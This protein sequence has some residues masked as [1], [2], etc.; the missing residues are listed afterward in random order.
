MW[1]FLGFS[2]TVFWKV[3]C[4]KMRNVNFFD[5]FRHCHQLR[6]VAIMP[7]LEEPFLTFFSK[8]IMTIIFVNFRRCNETWNMIMLWFNHFFFLIFTPKLN[9]VPLQILAFVISNFDSPSRLIITSIKSQSCW[10]PRTT[11]FDVNMLTGQLTAKLSWISSG[12][13]INCQPIKTNS[14]GFFQVKN[15]EIDT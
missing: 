3:Q 4:L 10:S 6:L 15:Q 7:H 1:D 13:S 8:R 9:L 14:R 11:S 12:R 5:L 2:N